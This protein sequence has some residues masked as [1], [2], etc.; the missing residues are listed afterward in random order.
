MKNLAFNW[1][2]FKKCL[3]VAKP[4]SSS[5]IQINTLTES[6]I[7]SAIY[8]PSEVSTIQMVNVAFTQ[9][10]FKESLLVVN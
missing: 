8:H 4:M 3:L 7:S 5:I 9:N 1:N 6:S 10:S 2:R